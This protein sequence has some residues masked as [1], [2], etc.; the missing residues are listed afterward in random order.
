VRPTTFPAADDMVALRDQ[1]GGT[2]EIEIRNGLAE[3]RHESLDVFPSPTWLV[4]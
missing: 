2:S 4:Q 1:I 3:M